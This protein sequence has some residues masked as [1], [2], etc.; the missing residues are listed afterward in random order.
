MT[1]QN[2][3][4]E[5]DYVNAKLHSREMDDQSFLGTFLQACLRA[6]AENYE[7]LRQTLFLMMFKYPSDRESIQRE[8]HARG[9]NH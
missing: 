8:R 4:I 9:A 2:Y 1:I 3:P 7:L 5:L 6:D